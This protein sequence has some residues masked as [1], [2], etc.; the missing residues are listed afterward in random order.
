[1][2]E[3]VMGLSP[4]PEQKKGI[5]G[6]TLKIVAMV[7]MLLD[8]FGAVVLGRLLWSTGYV[9]A[10]NSGA[11]ELIE[12]M[13]E[14]MIL[15]LSY[16]VLRMIGRIAFP[17]FIFLMVEGFERTS[18]RWKY[19]ARMAV[20]ALVSEVPFDLALV[21]RVWNPLY[22]SV[23][24][25][26]GLGLLAMIL[27]DMLEQRIMK[28][29]GRNRVINVIVAILITAVFYVA[30]DMLHTDYGGLGI[31][32]IM[33]VFFFRRN[34]LH[35][36]IAGCITFVWE[37]TAPLAFLLTWF[38]NGKRGLKL[39]YVFYLFYP[40]HLLLLYIISYLMGLGTFPAL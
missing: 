12:W 6:S 27:Y 33:V 13:N 16:T 18:N 26:L 4:V 1:M 11:Y 38:Y 30:A 35:Q 22:Q 24:F 37:L 32:C 21:G 29:V 20:F 3:M 5:S 40:V 8:H 10:V 34:K 15:Y 9:V 36:T 23:Y 31:I 39:K 2:A 7:V 14:N 25:T 17:I 28:K 19:L